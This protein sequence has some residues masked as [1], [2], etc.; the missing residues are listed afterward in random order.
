VNASLPLRDELLGRVGVADLAELVVS[1]SDDEPA[2]RLLS[3]LTGAPTS[4]IAAFEEELAVRLDGSPLAM[5]LN[6]A[7][8]DRSGEFF[9]AASEVSTKAALRLREAAGGID[10]VLSKLYEFSPLL[11]EAR[12]VNDDRGDVSDVGGGISAKPGESEDDMR[13]PYGYARLLAVSDP[14][15]P[16]VEAHVREVGRVLLRCLPE[17]NRVDVAALLPGDVAL[18]I[19]E[20]VQAVSGLRRRY[21][22]GS[23]QVAWNRLRSQVATEAAGTMDPT[24]RAQTAVALVQDVHAFLDDFTRAW[25]VSRGR[26]RDA[27]RLEASRQDLRIRAERLTMPMDRSDLFR[28]QPGAAPNSLSADHLHTLVDG[29]IDHIAPRAQRGDWAS[30]AGYVGDTLR[31]AVRQ[32]RDEERWS[33]VGYEA[34]SELE[35]MDRMLVDLHA[36]LAEL[37]WGNLRTSSVTAAARSGPS[38]V[39]LGRAADMARASA[40]NRWSACWKSLVR[41][42][43]QARLSVRVLT[44]SLDDPDASD[45]PAFRAAV[46]MDVRGV[47]DWLE[48]LP[49][50]AEVLGRGD[51]SN[52]TVPIVLVPTIEERP[53]PLFAMQLMTT[54]WPGRQEF[55]AEWT[56]EFPASWPTPLANAA[57]EAHQALQELSAL[58]AL[59]RRRD[60]TDGQQRQAELEAAKFNAAFEL[61]AR[62]RDEHTDDLFLQEIVGFLAAT[63]ERVQEEV[64]QGSS[65]GRD[66][67][68]LAAGIALGVTGAPTVDFAALDTLVAV[69]A[70]W[71][72][73]PAAAGPLLT[74][75]TGSG[76][77]PDAGVTD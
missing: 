9:A 55:S 54:L 32:V 75:L 66:S 60:V 34:P 63:A 76:G 62:L 22:Y 64:D 47:R 61:V 56:E 2:L 70:Q 65:S 16:D 17:S 40:R 14:A 72:L 67:D 59:G 1:C 39:A 69:T 29:I 27:N 11:I 12:L 49:I 77:A 74:E 6:A 73:D 3:V 19:G 36:V 24:T 10:G 58:A 7:P 31:R 28:S 8:A 48:R 43:G 57:V 18:R 13:G 38:D 4:V 51:D 42:A 33:L 52:H 50:L 23:A 41:K 21:D 68:T 25:C 30:L 35:S 5:L 20:H 45:W 53:V 71:D 46:A 44:M 15:V 37:A 26:A